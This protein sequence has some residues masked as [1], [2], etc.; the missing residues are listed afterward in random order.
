MLVSFKIV[1]LVNGYQKVWVEKLY[2][3]LQDPIV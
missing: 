3:K 2:V 1:S